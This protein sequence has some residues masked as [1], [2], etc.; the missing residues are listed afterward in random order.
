MEHC[1]IKVSSDIELAMVILQI[2]N[3]VSAH[4]CVVCD[5]ILTSCLCICKE[6]DVVFVLYGLWE[7]N[8]FP[9]QYM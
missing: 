6:I 4:A 8:V 9:A 5:Y 1:I 3:Y 2:D 7:M